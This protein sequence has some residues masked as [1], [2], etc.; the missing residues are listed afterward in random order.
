MDSIA[1][2]HRLANLNNGAPLLIVTRKADSPRLGE[3]ILEP[4][5]VKA[6]LTEKEIYLQ[7]SQAEF[8]SLKEKPHLIVDVVVV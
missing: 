4:K 7:Y 6:L 3:P 1:L 5:I 8:D 2:S